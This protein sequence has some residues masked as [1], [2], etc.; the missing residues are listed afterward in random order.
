MD[1]VNHM[2]KRHFD[3]NLANIA[4]CN[5]AGFTFAP[6]DI[7]FNS[8]YPNLTHGFKWDK[9]FVGEDLEFGGTPGIHPIG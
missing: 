6:T 3:T 1:E 4:P 5:S 2:D 7:S 9:E 8:F